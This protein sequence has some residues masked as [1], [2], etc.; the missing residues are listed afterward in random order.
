MECDLCHFALKKIE[1][2]LLALY[3]LPANYSKSRHLKLKDGQPI[4]GLLQRKNKPLLY[5][6]HCILGAI[7]YRS[8]GEPLV[9]T[10]DI[11]IN[12]KFLEGDVISKKQS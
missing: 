2:I 1:H 7:C 10:V 8:L 3:S 12:A 4:S 5:L 6:T 9:S 11:P